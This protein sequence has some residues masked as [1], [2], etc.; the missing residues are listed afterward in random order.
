MFA[1]PHDDA[2]MRVILCNIALIT[3]RTVSSGLMTGEAIRFGRDASEQFGSAILLGGGDHEVRDEH[4]FS[5][6]QV[7]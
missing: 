6:F 4:V 2:S 5:L 3:A 7:L 1:Q